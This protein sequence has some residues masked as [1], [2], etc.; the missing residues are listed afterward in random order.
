MSTDIQPRPA[1]V[2]MVTVQHTSRRGPSTARPDGDRPPHV[3]METGRCLGFLRGGPPHAFGKPD[4]KCGRNGCLWTNI[5]PDVDCPPYLSLVKSA[6]ALHGKACA[7][8][9]V[10]W[11]LIRFGH[12]VSLLL[13]ASADIHLMGRSNHL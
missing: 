2:R 13:R 12:G 6:R 7:S 3:L 5:R 1:D 10:T 8:N 4:L 11:D 9:R